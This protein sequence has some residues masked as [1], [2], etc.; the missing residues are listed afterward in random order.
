MKKAMKKTMKKVMAL[1]GII[2]FAVLLY[3]CDT[4]PIAQTIH[5]NADFSGSRVIELELSAT[6]V[7]DSGNTSTSVTYPGL[8]GIPYYRIRQH[9]PTLK[10]YLE[11]ALAADSNTGVYQWNVQIDDSAI[12]I[13][14]ANPSYPKL[15]DG[16]E[17]IRITFEFDNFA[18]YTAKMRALASFGGAS[19][20]F[21]RD[22]N[23]YEYEDP[24]LTVDVDA[25]TA[26]YFERGANTRFLYA[27]LWAH[28]IGDSSM[29]TMG[30]C[31]HPDGTTFT[32]EKGNSFNDMFYD[33]VKGK[34][35]ALQAN[36]SKKTL[37]ALTQTDGMTQG[38]PGH[39]YYDINTTLS[40]TVAWKDFFSGPF[41]V[42]GNS[43]TYT[44]GNPDFKWFAADSAG[45]PTGQPLTT[46]TTYTH[47]FSTG[48]T[49]KKIVGV[50]GTAQYVKTLE[51]P[52]VQTWTVTFLDWDDEVLG[53]VTVEEGENV[54]QNQ[55][56]ANP[57]TRDDGKVFKNWEGNL[58]NITQNTTIR[59][60]YGDP[61]NGGGG[62]GCKNSLFTNGSLFG[63]VLLLLGSY[64]FIN[65]QRRNSAD[66]E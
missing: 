64:M 38:V 51:I 23:F 66:N 11:Q 34:S 54:P 4:A 9:G 24:T 25:K 13:P 55:I 40:N 27:G 5:F 52:P 26:T 62:G 60:I 3:A 33:G 36:G 50:D 42:D 15:A 10:T 57:G 41:T 17:V 37:I 21:S 18:E 19:L 59:A 39:T 61:D 32:V 6:P 35:I 43:V 22:G 58:T 7:T 16:K 1:C 28:M 2:V 56:P 65:K 53:T 8:K 29:V 12:V 46:S 63:G 45:K 47:T 20:E 31:Y 48:E 14:S 49:S 30:Q 44:G